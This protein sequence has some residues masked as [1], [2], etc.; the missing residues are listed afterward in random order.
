MFYAND[1]V[2]QIK[3]KSKNYLEGLSD[4]CPAFRNS[5]AGTVLDNLLENFDYIIQKHKIS[6][7]I[8]K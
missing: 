8:E 2:D 5:Y 4:V 7:C 1:K 3:E 6:Q